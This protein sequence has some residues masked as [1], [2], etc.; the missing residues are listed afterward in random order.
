MNLR[1]SIYLSSVLC[2]LVSAPAASVRTEYPE[3][4]RSNS[5]TVKLT[6]IG[7][8][9]ES[10][11]VMVQTNDPMDDWQ[12][13]QQAALEAWRIE[14]RTNHNARPP[15]TPLLTIPNGF[16]SIRT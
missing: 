11:A 7:E 2:A 1:T 16:P 5:V 12:K 10:M 14:V 15:M 6:P 13:N 9:P 4:V 3:M 8:V